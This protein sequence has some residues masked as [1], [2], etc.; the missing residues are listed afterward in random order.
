MRGRDFDLGRRPRARRETLPI[1][2]E[3]YA[4]VPCCSFA[5]RQIVAMLEDGID[6]LRVCRAIRAGLH[7]QYKPEDQ[8]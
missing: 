3:A 8:E 2:Q 7:L 1:Y 4:P 6:P 5:E